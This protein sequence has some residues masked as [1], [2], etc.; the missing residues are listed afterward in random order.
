[1]VLRLPPFSG[2]PR[3]YTRD[4][5]P[6]AAR[7]RW[8]LPTAVPRDPPANIPA[9]IARILR[10]RGVADAEMAAFLDP[11]PSGLG[12]PMLGMERAIERITGALAAGERIVVYG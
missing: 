9:L 1:M 12:P 3:F 11:S 7:R 5:M 4:L 6:L 10:A 8:I 2:H